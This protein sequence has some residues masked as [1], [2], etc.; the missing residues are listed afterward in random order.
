MNSF[1]RSLRAAYAIGLGIITAGIICGD[2]L[3]WKLCHPG[4]PWALWPLR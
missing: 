4:T 1:D 2:Y 3:I